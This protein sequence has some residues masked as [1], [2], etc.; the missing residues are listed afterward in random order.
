MSARCSLMSL[1][2]GV[3]TMVS[4]F[5]SSGDGCVISTWWIGAGSFFAAL[6]VALPF[7]SGFPSPWPAALARPSTV[8]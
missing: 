2:P 7:P 1:T 8:R 5:A 6:P 4:R 3:S